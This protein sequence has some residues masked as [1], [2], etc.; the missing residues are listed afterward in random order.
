VPELP[1]VQ[2]IVNDLRSSIRGW[3]VTDFCSLWEKNVHGGEAS[4]FKNAIIGKKI[5]NI[6]RRAKYILIELEGG[7]GILVHLRMTGALLVQNPKSKIQISNNFKFS[8]SNFKKEQGEQKH[9][10][11]G[12]L[13]IKGRN[14]KLLLF[15]DI[16]KFGTVD[17]VDLKKINDHKKVCGLGSEP[18][19][20]GFTSDTLGEILQKKKSQIVR[21]VLLDQK[22]I[23]GIGNIYVSEILFDAKIDPKR[24]SGEI[25]RKE[26]AV[27][28]ES[29]K[30]ILAKAIEFRGTTFSDYRDSKG[31]K[32]GFQNKLKVYNREHGRCLR[33]GCRGMITKQKI[34]QR[35]AYWCPVCQR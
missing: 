30:K 31:E 26:V 22:C 1:E 28:H 21:N 10:R 7:V 5:A 11:H 2:T 14:K 4:A 23:C 8:I 18:L 20:D 29:I 32:G 16:R 24:R 12:W 3:T 17:L 19:S 15:S 34:N 6:S 9:I 25:S 35:S 27:L 13:I 33:R